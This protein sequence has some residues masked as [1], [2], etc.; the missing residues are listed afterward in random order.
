MPPT[1]TLIPLVITAGLLVLALLWPRVRTGPTG[2][3]LAAEMTSIALSLVA[4]LSALLM[5]ARR[6]PW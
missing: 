4:L 5:A 6:L 3:R 2:A 1:F